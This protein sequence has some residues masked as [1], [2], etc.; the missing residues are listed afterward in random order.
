MCK[1]GEINDVEFPEGKLASSWRTIQFILV[2]TATCSR[3]KL[4]KQQ[5][6]NGFHLSSLEST[7]WCGNKITA[8]AALWCAIEVPLSRNS[9]KYVPPFFGSRMPLET[10]TLKFKTQYWA[11]GVALC[12]TCLNV[13]ISP[14][15]K[16]WSLILFTVRNLTDCAHASSIYLSVGNLIT[17]L[18]LWKRDS[19]NM[20]HAELQN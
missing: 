9:I 20:Y 8:P 6:I 15:K 2:C 13:W 7:H 18:E 4:N 17:Y 3:S 11:I 16:G 14:L 1:K 5:I 19:L 12:I 10:M